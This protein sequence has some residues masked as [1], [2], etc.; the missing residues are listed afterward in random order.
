[1]NNSATGLNTWLEPGSEALFIRAFIVVI[2]VVWGYMAYLLLFKA[3]RK[4]IEPFI[5]MSCSLALYVPS[6]YFLF[7]CV[8]HNFG[9]G[10]SHEERAAEFGL[11]GLIWSLSVLCMVLSI[12]VLVDQIG[13]R[14]IRMTK[15]RSK[16]GGY[17]VTNSVDLIDEY[18]NNPSKYER[19]Q[20]REAINDAKI[21]YEY[22]NVSRDWYDYVV[23]KLTPYT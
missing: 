2:L 5:L 20:L 21:H 16:V 1:M 14:Q 17:T 22:G 19:W 15:D 9:L 18:C 12:K 4:Q 10:S 3:N 8:T 23:R 13:T 6:F 11:A 7:R